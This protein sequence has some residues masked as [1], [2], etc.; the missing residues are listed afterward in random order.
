MRV[1]DPRRGAPPARLLVALSIVAV[2]VGGFVAGRGSVV[3]HPEARHPA[4]GYP[5]GYAAGRE[6]AFEGFDGGWSFDTPYVVTLRRGGPG[7]TY[8]FAR[9]WPMR[10]G[11]AYRV[12]G[13]VVCGRTVP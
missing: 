6:A 11:V 3:G 7:V 8:R 4:G 13:R 1:A 2:G 9:R 12:C 5:A 10:R